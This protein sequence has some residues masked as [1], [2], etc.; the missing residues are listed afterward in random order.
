[1]WRAALARTADALCLGTTKGG[2]P[3]HPLFVRA[4]A[5]PVS[6]ADR[7]AGREAGQ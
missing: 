7:Q 2:E 4:G 3:R 6:L 5:V 1:M